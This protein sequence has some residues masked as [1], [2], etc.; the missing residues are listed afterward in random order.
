MTTMITVAIGLV[1]D[2]VYCANTLSREDV[3]KI[4]AFIEE[5]LQQ[6]GSESNE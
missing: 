2:V 3:E 5:V 6:S 1:T 4:K